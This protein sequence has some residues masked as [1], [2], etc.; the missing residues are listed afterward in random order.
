MTLPAM[1]AKLQMVSLH[2]TPGFESGVVCCS[3]H[4]DSALVEGPLVWV[5]SQREIKLSCP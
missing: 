3:F 1:R 2:V 4:L 5:A